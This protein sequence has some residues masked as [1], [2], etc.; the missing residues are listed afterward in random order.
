MVAQSCATPQKYQE[1]VSVTIHKT[2]L[3]L[4]FLIKAPLEFSE[5][6]LTQLCNITQIL[7][8]FKEESKHLKMNLILERNLTC[9]NHLG[10]CE[11]SN[12]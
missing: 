8:T 5:I 9:N 7:H 12:I 10:I 3:H 2:D 6:I 11:S 1:L 4:I